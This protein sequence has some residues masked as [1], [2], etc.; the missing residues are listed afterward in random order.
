LSRDFDIFGFEPGSQI[1]RWGDDVCYEMDTETDTLTMTSQGE[2]YCFYLQ[3][4]APY[5]IKRW[6]EKKIRH[7]GKVF[8]I[9]AL[10]LLIALILSYF[11]RD[12][13][14]FPYN[15]TWLFIL[16]TIGVIIFFLF[17]CDQFYSV[18]D[19][20]SNSRCKKCG[21]DF[22]YEEFRKPLTRKVS[23]PESFE[24]TRTKYRKCRYCGDED[25]ETQTDFI[26][27]KGDK[28]KLTDDTC[29][30]CGKE[31]S[32]KEHRRP[33]VFEG[34]DTAKTIRYYKCSNCGYQ[35]I[36]VEKVEFLGPM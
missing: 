1:K 36:T 5:L 31:H 16:M 34:A 19:F 8:G 24:I 4:E 22:A 11:F 23:T 26:D 32:I 13:I 17:L 9:L 15:M 33:D 20:Y 6:G 10:L 21:K 3:S 30:R 25:F 27:C 12:R 2:I 35:E 18:A 14:V 28:E 29:K 7:I